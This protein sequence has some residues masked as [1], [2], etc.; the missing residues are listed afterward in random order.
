MHQDVA[1][2]TSTHFQKP[3]CIHVWEEKFANFCFFLQIPGSRSLSQ[4]QIY[5]VHVCMVQMDDKYYIFMVVDLW[6]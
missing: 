3:L 6:Q 4:E 2:K 5:F 1:S